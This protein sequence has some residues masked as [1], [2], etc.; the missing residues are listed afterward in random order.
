MFVTVLICPLLL[1]Y[2]LPSMFIIRESIF[3]SCL[4]LGAGNR[5]A[6]MPTM[7]A[8]FVR[9]PLSCP[10]ATRSLTP[11]GPDT[12]PPVS[13]AAFHDGPEAMAGAMS[14]PAELGFPTRSDRS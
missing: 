13:G 8:A 14:E 2:R 5:A 4:V 10:H 3:M 6:L 11:C 12:G 1:G 7:N 9:V